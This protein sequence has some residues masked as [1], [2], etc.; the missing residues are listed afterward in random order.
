MSSQ[1]YNIDG[2]KPFTRMKNHLIEN[3]RW[4]PAYIKN[5]GI[6]GLSVNPVLFATNFGPISTL[7]D[8][9]RMDESTQPGIRIE[10]VSDT[11][12][13]PANYANATISM[14]NS[15]TIG[16][17]IGLRNPAVSGNDGQDIIL[18]APSP[19]GILTGLTMPTGLPT[20]Y[21][22]FTARQSAGGIP[23]AGWAS[24][25]YGASGVDASEQQT[26]LSLGPFPVY[27]TLQDLADIIDSY[28]NTGRAWL[29]HGLAER[30]ASPAYL[31]TY[32]DG[33]TNMQPVNAALTADNR[34]ADAG[35]VGSK[36]RAGLHTNVW[37][38]TVFM[39]MCL[40]VNQF[41]KNMTG[42]S[43]ISEP[44]FEK[45]GGGSTGGF[46]KGFVNISTGDQRA[47]M[48][49]RYDPNP[50][51]PDAANLTWKIVGESGD[52]KLGP[53]FGKGNNALTPTIEGTLQQYVGDKTAPNNARMQQG[54]MSGDSAT[55]PNP[56]YRMRMC[57]AIFLKDGDY[58]PTDGCLIPYVYD[59]ERYIGGKNTTTCYDTWSGIIGM[60]AGTYISGNFLPSVLRDVQLNDGT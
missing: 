9:E 34:A 47:Q 15:G 46:A 40:D 25:S 53:G 38:A 33:Q 36:G 37:R 58:T 54:F 7:E 16:A 35:V 6:G 31:A 57:L 28:N 23:D 29:P 24:L 17:V 50:T 45:S 60:D 27:A 12:T 4:W 20:S 52:H 10:L 3:Q 43:G 5:D 13:D 39:P 49:S 42:F 19:E 2:S 21:T 51:G 18:V 59:S 56:K 26:G 41:S 8:G 55:V 11:G 48:T 30:P 1:K 14:R 44:R 32:T 22:G